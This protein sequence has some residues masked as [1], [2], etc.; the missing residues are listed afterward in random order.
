MTTDNGQRTKDNGSG[1]H[2]VDEA[3]RQ[4][5]PSAT[6]GISQCID[7]TCDRFEAA[8]RAGERPQLE[9]HLGAVAESGGAELLR[10]LLAVELA[11]RNRLGEHPQAAEYRSRFPRD[12]GLI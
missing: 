2:I 4:D 5:H 7:E 3:T 8:W 9:D 10:H 1:E 12:D 6:V 11:Y